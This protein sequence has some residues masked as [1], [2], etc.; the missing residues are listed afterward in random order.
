MRMVK[1]SQQ[2]FAVSEEFMV[3]GSEQR[4]VVSEDGEG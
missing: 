4:F 2:R 3:R 1:G